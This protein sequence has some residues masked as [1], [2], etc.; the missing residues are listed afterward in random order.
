MRFRHAPDGR[1]WA[2][3]RGRPPKAPEGYVR[4]PKD[5]FCF[6]PILEDCDRRII[7]ETKCCG[8]KTKHVMF[9]TKSNKRVTYKECLNCDL[10]S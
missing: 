7:K 9:C 10:Q 5:K 3:V 4:D 8:N 1:L 2:P 6:I